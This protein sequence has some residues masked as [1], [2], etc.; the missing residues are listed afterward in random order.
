MLCRTLNIM[1]G[2]CVCVPFIIVIRFLFFVDFIRNERCM[3]SVTG[4]TTC[5]RSTRRETRYARAEI[6]TTSVLAKCDTIKSN[7]NVCIGLGQ[8]FTVS[9][10][11]FV[12]YL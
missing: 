1:C 8:I 10:F 9:V 6:Q 11:C 7:Y 3:E 2:V 12:S 5:T 4:R